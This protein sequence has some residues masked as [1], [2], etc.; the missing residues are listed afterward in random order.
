MTPLLPPA[1]IGVFGSGQLGRMLGLAAR[2]MG[3][4]FHT[5]SPHADSP[6]G[7][8]ADREVV[9]AYTDVDAVRDFIRHVDVVTFEFE[10]V[11]AFVAEVAHSQGVP[12]RPGGH[13]LHTA[14][15]RL[16][17]KRFLAEN[18]LPIAPFRAVT[19]R[20]ELQEAV[21]EL[22][23]PA[24]LKTAAFGYDG[25]GQILLRSS[26]EIQPAWE[27][28]G[29]E[30]AIL[31]TFVDFAAEISVVAARSEDG[32]FVNYGVIENVHRH[33]ILDISI[34]PAR[35]PL[36]IAAQ[37][38][39][40]AQSVL[41]KL[42]VI[43]VLCVEYFVTKSGRVLINEIAPRPHNSGH[44][45]IDAA[46]N[47]QFDQQVRS[48]CGLPLGC[49]DYLRPAV[50][51]NLLGD[52]WAEGE[53]NWAAALAVPGVKLHLYG[54]QEARPGRKMGHLTATADSIDEALDAVIRARNA[55]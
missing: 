26:E 55:L 52:L 22:G 32:D 42:D 53:P 15:N 35:T 17:E 48:V 10:N 16:R 13:V 38:A 44:L 37:A 12:V 23:L 6:A 24:L 20:D 21:Q 9:A 41:E 47:S 50:M 11:P 2:S 1:V 40:L 14:Q 43:G 8:V 45:T 28:L 39:D 27:A 33:H 30:T 31:E 5:F 51:A 49:T 4:G 25:K 18:G 7:Q 29:A 36:R 54:K 19:S 34:A 46:V 3:Y